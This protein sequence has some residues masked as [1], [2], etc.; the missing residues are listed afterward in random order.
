MGLDLPAV[1]EQIAAARRLEM[2]RNRL[3]ALDLVVLAG[4][5]QADAAGRLCQGNLR[6]VLT[7]A[8]SLSRAGASTPTSSSDRA[9]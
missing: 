5:D 6:R 1:E 2:V 7:S 3:L 8:L 4:L 9:V